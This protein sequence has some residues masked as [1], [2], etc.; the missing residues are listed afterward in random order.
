MRSMIC[1]VGILAV[2]AVDPALEFEDGA[3]VCKLSL[4]DGEILSE[5]PLTGYATASALAL[6]QQDVIDIKADILVLQ[7]YHDGTPPP[8]GPSGCGGSLAW[9]ADTGNGDGTNAWTPGVAHSRGQSNNRSPYDGSIINTEFVGDFTVDIEIAGQTWV[10]GGVLF[11]DNINL[12]D[13]IG[14]PGTTE[15]A[16]GENCDRLGFPSGYCASKS[17]T[18]VGGYSIPG[19]DNDAASG[20]YTYVRIQRIGNDAKM[21]YWN[22]NSASPTSDYATN[23]VLWKDTTISGSKSIVFMGEAGGHSNQFHASGSS[24]PGTYTIINVN[25]AECPTYSSCKAIKNANPD[26]S[27]GTYTI[28]LSDSSD[29]E[30]YCDMAGAGGWTLLANQQQTSNNCQ[31]GAVGTFTSL[32]QS[33]SYRLSDDQIADIQGSGDGHFRYSEPGYNSCSGDGECT[34]SVYWKYDA[35]VG[36]KNHDF[37]SNTGTS[38][39]NKNGNLHHCSTKLNGDYYGEDGGTCYRYANGSNDDGTGANN[40]LC[41][42]TSHYGLDTWATGGPHNGHCGM[43]FIWCYGSELYRDGAASSTAGHLWVR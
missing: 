15:N 8:P 30:V 34:E 43:Y 21:F 40:G 4:V 39:F 24:L 7:G 13:W 28:V 2:S 27:D 38:G 37:H 29:L 9:K 23:F 12:G 35:G 17:A 14:N 6:V 11:G 10:G 1:L 31:S 42:Y 16:Y 41:G 36:T 20:Q 33:S 26:A 22:S 25:R 32:T 18:Y 5:C 3:T 19:T